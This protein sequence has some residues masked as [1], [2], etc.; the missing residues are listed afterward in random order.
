M[1]INS[2]SSTTPNV[3]FPSKRILNKRF[4]LVLHRTVIGQTFRIRANFTEPLKTHSPAEV[5]NVYIATLIYSL[6]IVDTVDYT[7]LAN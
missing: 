7:S 5:G 4:W 6:L 1:K 3:K 2:Y